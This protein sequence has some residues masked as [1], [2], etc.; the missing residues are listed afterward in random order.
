MDCE[1]SHLRSPWSPQFPTQ[2]ARGGRRQSDLP[3]PFPHHIPPYFLPPLSSSA[4]A[5]APQTPAPPAPRR[6]QA[7]SPPLFLPPPTTHPPFLSFLLLIHCP[8][9]QLRRVSKS[10]DQQQTPLRHHLLRGRHPRPNSLQKR[11]R[12]SHLIRLQVQSLRRRS[13]SGANE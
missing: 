8:R 13:M 4:A 5:A 2:N 11:F 3:S 10:R 6:H 12:L 7:P 1:A 9:Y